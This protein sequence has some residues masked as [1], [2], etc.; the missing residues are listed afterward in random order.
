MDVIVDDNGQCQVL[1]LNPRPTA[2][3]ELHQTEQSL[4]EAH[5]QACEG[6]LM[7]LP[8]HTDV[9]RA[10]QVQYAVR[11]FIMPDITWPDWASDRP[12][13]GRRI[14]VNDPVCMVHAQAMCRNDIEAVLQHRSAILMQL[15]GLQKLAA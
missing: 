13:P 6:R 14:R 12:H 4:C 2:T 7:S 10:H 9:L 8:Y 11:D 5:I 15:M 3:F 1:E